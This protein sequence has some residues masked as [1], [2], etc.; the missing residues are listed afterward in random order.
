MNMESSELSEEEFEQPY[1]EGEGKLS[2]SKLRK[3]SYTERRN[4]IYA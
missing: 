4:N 3:M 1:N 2:E